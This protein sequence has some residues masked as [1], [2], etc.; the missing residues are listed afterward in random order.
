MLKM[1]KARSSKRTLAS[2]VLG[3]ESF[4]VFFA[5]LA[6]FGLKSADAS[7]SLPAVEWIW[8]IGLSW[9]IL[10]ILTPGILSKPF[11]YWVGSVLQAGILFSGFYLW[12]MFI[13]GAALV[14]L[15]I[16]ALVAGSTIDRG[17]EA[18]L[19]K[20]EEENND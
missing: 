20:K 5:T 14:G 15:W 3:F 13:I 10:C 16:W 4:V 2:I 17:R 9:A 1:K 7:D 8:A 12:G 19:K 18:Y 6:A 11:G